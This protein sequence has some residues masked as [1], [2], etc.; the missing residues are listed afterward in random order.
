MS[1]FSKKKRADTSINADYAD[2]ADYPSSR[3][4]PDLSSRSATLAQA[5]NHQ[6]LSHAGSYEGSHY[7]SNK[8]PTPK[9][10]LKTG[11]AYAAA[12]S[13]ELSIWHIYANGPGAKP[14][15]VDPYQHGIRASTC[16]PRS[17]KAVSYSSDDRRRMVARKVPK[18][19][20]QQNTEERINSLIDDMRHS[21]QSLRK[22]DMKQGMV[23]NQEHFPPVLPLNGQPYAI[24]TVQQYSQQVSKQ[25]VPARS[26]RKLSKNMIIQQSSQGIQPLF[27]QTE[28]S[29]AQPNQTC[30][31]A[32]FS[33]FSYPIIPG[34]LPR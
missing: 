25:S 21:N 19:G 33:D 4:Y 29:P 14:G 18:N 13:E 34:S 12:P 22:K 20:R 15:D 24:A 32:T 23:E 17:S 31:Q 27:Q 16:L 5:N 9:Y 28:H 10:S 6:H 11:K 2:Y 26:G 3:F 7:L 30:R 1:L 8:T